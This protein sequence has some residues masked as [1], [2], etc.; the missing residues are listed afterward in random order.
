[1]TLQSWPCRTTMGEYVKQEILNR[2]LIYNDH[3]FHFVIN[4]GHTLISDFD[5]RHQPQLCCNVATF[6]QSPSTH[7]PFDQFKTCQ[8]LYLPT[9]KLGS[10]VCLERQAHAAREQWS[11]IPRKNGQTSSFKGH[12]SPTTLFEVPCRLLQIDVVCRTSNMTWV[13]PYHRLLV[14]FI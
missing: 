4:P 5:G 2:I 3:V 13:Q 8:V 1:M 12:R 7:A 10:L 11:N 9:W 14:T 6:F